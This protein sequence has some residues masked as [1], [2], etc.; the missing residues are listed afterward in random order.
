MFGRERKTDYDREYEQEPPSDLEPALVPPLLR[1]SP[2]CGSLE[3]TATLFDLIRRGRF[4]SKPVTTVEKRFLVHDHQVADLELSRGKDVELETFEKPVA[5]LVDAL[6]ADGPKRLTE[7]REL[8]SKDREANS[9]RF[10]F[11][12]RLVRSQIRRRRWVYLGWLCQLRVRRRRGRRRLADALAI[13]IPDHH[14]DEVRFLDSDDLTRHLRPFAIAALLVTDETGIG[15][16]FAHNADL[17]LLG[18]SLFKPVGKPVG[19]AIAHHHDLDRGL[20]ARRGRR[21]VR[22]IRGLFLFDLP[23]PFPQAGSRSPFT[24]PITPVVRLRITAKAAAIVR[25]LRLAPVP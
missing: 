14:H 12:K 10:T 23:G 3:F 1:Q 5:E 18:K 6:V 9:E 15:A 4:E 17:G 21:S 8:I 24:L 20:L 16:V 22:V 13:V 25:L 2:A 7:F 11:F 19:V